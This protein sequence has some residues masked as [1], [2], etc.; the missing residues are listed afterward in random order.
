[1]KRKIREAHDTLENP[2]ADKPE[3][4][5]EMP[6]SYKLV[7]LE[8]S[9]EGDVV[10]KNKSFES[11]EKFNEFKQEL[12][13]NP[14]FLQIQHSIEPSFIDEMPGPKSEEMEKVKIKEL[15]FK[16]LIK[17]LILQEIKQIKTYKLKK[18]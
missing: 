5:G 9:N 18:Y 1:M 16:K 8:F 15:K 4:T 2:K 12:E 6:S 11:L 13:L 17:K 3:K 14:N 10:S 7:W